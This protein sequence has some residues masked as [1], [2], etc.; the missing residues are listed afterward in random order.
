MAGFVISRVAALFFRHHHA[1]A[2]GAHQD[3]VFGF[4]KV[5][6][7][8]RTRIAA[9]CHQCGFIAQ[10]CQ[11]CTR[12]A[13]RAARNHHRANV[14][15]QRN[16]AHVH[17]Q[18]LLTTA[19]VGQRDINLTVKTP[20]SEQRCVQDVRTVRSSHH[21]DAH[22]GFEAVHL[23]QHLIECL[24]TLVIT[25]TQART[26]LATYRINL[27]N[28]NDAGRIFLGVVKHVPHT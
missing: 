18:N 16:L 4:F 19:N 24:L 9:R 25:T 11:V 27:I 14:L 10:V 12:H 23:H 15:P 1:F 5:L 26:A 2:L 17:I 3:F 21:D 28:K 8:N 22:V 13:R 7:F 20:W 6:H